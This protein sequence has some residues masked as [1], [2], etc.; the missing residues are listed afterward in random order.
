M[1]LP[2][3]SK[4]CCGQLHQLT[5]ANG[6]RLRYLAAVGRNSIVA[7]ALVVKVRVGPVSG[8]FNQPQLQHLAD[9]SIQHARAQLQFALGARG[10]FALNRIAV[11]FAPAE[12]QKDVEDGW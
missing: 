4:P 12:G 10:D 1:S 5:H 7:A 8:L 2:R 11:S 3:H 9:R 6:F